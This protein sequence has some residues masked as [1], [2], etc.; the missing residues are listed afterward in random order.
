MAFKNRLLATAAIPLIALTWMSPV[1]AAELLRPAQP[2]EVQSPIVKVQADDDQELLKQ[3]RQERREKR[4]QQAEG[5]DQTQQT[6]QEQVKPR[7]KKDN[8]ANDQ[9]MQQDD[10]GQMQTQQ[11]DQEQVKPRRKKQQAADDQQMQMQDDSGQMQQSDQEP[12]K[13]RKKKHQAADDQQ[14]QQDDSGQVQTQQSD[15]EPVKP[16][17]K[18]QN[19]NAASDQ[20]QSDDQQLKNAIDNNNKRHRKQNAADEQQMQGQDQS[21]Q[22]Q[23]QQSDEEQV[24]PRHK[25]QNDNAASDQNQSDDEQLKNAIDNNNKKHRKQNAADEQQM[26]QDNADQSE[27]SDQGEVKP[28]RK[29]Q[30]DNATSDQNQSTDDKLKNAIDNNKHRKNKSNQD[31]AEQPANDNGEADQPNRKNKA[32]QPVDVKKAKDIAADPS[33]TTDTVVLPVE[34]GAAV[35]DSDKDAD[36]GGNDRDRRKREREEVTAKPAPK[37][38]KDAQRGFK[39]DEEI[40]IKPVLE[41]KGE[42]ISGFKGYDDI[43]GRRVDDRDNR[44]IINI[45]GK[46][47]IRNDDD[48]RLAR[49]TDIR[50]ERLQNNLIRE[51]IVQPNGDKIITVRNRYGEIVRR[52]RIERDNR[53]IVIFYSPDLERGRDRLFLRD[54]GDDLPPMRLTIPVDDYIIDVSGGGGHRNYEQ[55]LEEPPVERVERVYSVDEVK[56]SARIRDKMRR[57]DLDTITFDTGSSDIADDQVQSLKQVGQAIKSILDKDP[58][59]TFLIEGHTDAVGSDESNLVLSDQRAESVANVLSQ[60]F[61]IPAEN[62]VTQGYGERYLKIDTDEAER[63]NRRVTIRRITPLVRPLEAAQQ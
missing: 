54:P 48:R 4:R 40:R 56:N 42:R 33:K 7:H 30:Q 14:M 38:D 39:N 2:A 27:Q 10:S 60:A 5:A 19:D 13:P 51:V 34:N 29:N 55:F 8:A 35:L 62:L 44:V 57:I 24:K 12:V 22:M 58:G 23:T 47:V 31:Q 11:T 18:K 45:G 25:K 53:E 32:G 20:N 17:H 49:D 52:S 16:R 21:G 43:G 50:Y 59:E 37:S 15:Q 46:I 61:D 6:D 28:R 9:Q 26:Q 63:A 41:L 1:A 3:K 36:K